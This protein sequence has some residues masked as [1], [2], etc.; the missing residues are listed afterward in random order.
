ANVNEQIAVPRIKSIS[1][2]SRVTRPNTNIRLKRLSQTINVTLCAYLSRQATVRNTQYRSSIFHRA[3]DRIREMLSHDG[4][5]S[6]IPVV[7]DID[8]HV[9]SI[10]YQPPR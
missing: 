2:L 4:C 1:Y 6:E 10:M 9:G 5:R 7:R 3:K 8:Q